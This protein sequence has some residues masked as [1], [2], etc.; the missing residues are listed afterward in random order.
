LIL[1]E[2][3]TEPASAAAVIK[4]LDRFLEFIKVTPKK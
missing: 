1:D 2:R 4:I 3:V